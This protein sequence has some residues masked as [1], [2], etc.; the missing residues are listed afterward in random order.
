MIAK[1]ASM[2][3][4][5]MYGACMRGHLALA[6]LM[7]AHG[8]TGLNLALWAAC[9]HGHRALAKWAVAQGATHC[10]HCNSLEH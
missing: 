5:A 9:K 4:H 10:S 3:D 8:A 1:G 6:K 7:I 2:W